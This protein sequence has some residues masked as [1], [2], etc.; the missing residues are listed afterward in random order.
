MI[1]LSRNVTFGQYINNGSL[2]TRM[3]PRAKLASA[4]LLIALVSLVSRFSV[5]ALCMLFCVIVQWMS[6]I[7]VPY[8]LRSF[9]PLVIP[10][11]IIYLF[12]VVFYYSPTQHTSL[13]W[14][15]SI[16]A[17]SWEGILVSALT[18][19]RVLFLYYFASMLMFTTSL[20]DLTDGSEA[21]FSPL[22]RIG[23]PVNALVMILVI[24]FKF[25]PILVAE[26]E[27]LMK[28]QAARGVRFDKGNIFRRTIKLSSLL[29]PLFLSG[30]RRAEVLTTAM[31][32]RCYGSHRGWRRSKR[33][34]LRFE[35]F[36]ILALVFVLAFCI[37]AVLANI[38]ASI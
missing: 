16:F 28:A 22:Q 36:D 27:R 7:S 25:V 3:D 1:E 20:V 4:I 6:H 13:I 23:V 26:A 31:E 37:V 8:V 38:F 29:I 14:H 2:L 30:F 5:F 33:R 9:K 17:V 10:I 11:V 35:R 21:L 32:A 18:I 19:V 15:W 12:E 34:Q 24:A